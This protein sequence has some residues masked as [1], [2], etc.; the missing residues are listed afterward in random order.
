M[1]LELP[2]VDS[3]R[4]PEPEPGRLPCDAVEPGAAVGSGL[5]LTDAAITG[6]WRRVAGEIAGGHHL[7]WA[8][9]GLVA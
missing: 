5:P 2:T 9:A 4:A 7:L 1:Q 3:L 6:D 8:A